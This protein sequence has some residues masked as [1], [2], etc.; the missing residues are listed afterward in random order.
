L[1][2]HLIDHRRVVRVRLQIDI[3]VEQRPQSLLAVSSK[4]HD[5]LSRAFLVR[6]KLIANKQ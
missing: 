1:L 5:R 4:I 6:A 3:R 2:R